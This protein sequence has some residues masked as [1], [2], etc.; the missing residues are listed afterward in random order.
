MPESFAQLP[1]I[2][3]VALTLNAK[4][5]GVPLVDRWHQ[6]E[7]STS[8]AWLHRAK[9]AGRWLA[10]ARSIADL[11]CGHMLLETCLRP[12][13]TYL[14]VDFLPRDDRTVVVDFNT[15]PIPPL[16]AT[17]FAALGLFEYLYD[18]DGF[19]R[20]LRASF[21]GGVASFYTR[22]VDIHESRRLAN[23]W[24]NHQTQADIRA[25]LTDAGF[26]ISRALEFQPAHFL[27]RL[28]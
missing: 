18:L 7:L 19:L 2:E 9:R 26:R 15:Q 6:L 4:A 11:G 24:V 1:E 3:R 25:L 27:F 12:D 13:Q 5:D 16:A 20:S 17:H 28:D 8:K 21:K 10:D 22:G 14:P 23:G